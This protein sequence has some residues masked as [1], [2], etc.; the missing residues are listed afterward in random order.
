MLTIFMLQ[1]VSKLYPR[2]ECTICF[3]NRNLKQFCKSHKFCDKCCN[4]WS[5]TNNL[6]PLCRDICVNK[7][8]VKYNFELK[9]LN[10]ED[11]SFRYFDLYFKNWHSDTCIKKKHKFKIRKDSND[12]K[13][14]V[15]HCI[16]CN[17]EQ[18]FPV[19]YYLQSI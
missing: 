1:L 6:C 10:Y 15:F 17:I 19:R 18:L 16:D 12:D 11:Y 5:K 2:E 3:E 4:S 14:F 13:K 7:K 9:N 8:Y